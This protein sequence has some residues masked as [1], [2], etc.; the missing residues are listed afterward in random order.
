MK[1]TMLRL[2]SALVLVALAGCASF[3]EIKAKADGGDPSMQYRVGVC[4]RD[5]KDVQRNLDTAYDYFKK[6]ADGGSFA[7]AL[8]YAKE[9][10][11]RKDISEPEKFLERIQQVFIGKPQNGDDWDAR[12]EFRN[13]YPKFCIQYATLLR[14]DGALSK[15]II[16]EKQA[17]QYFDR[18]ILN[19]R[20]KEVNRHAQRLRSLRTATEANSLQRGI[21]REPGEELG[22][23]A[24]RVD[25][26]FNS[27]SWDNKA[28]FAA[29]EKFHEEFGADFSQE[30]KRK[31]GEND[32]KWV[33]RIGQCVATLTANGRAIDITR[34]IIDAEFSNS[35][36]DTALASVIRRKSEEAIDKWAERVQ[37]R[38]TP[39]DG[40]N[41]QL[42]SQAMDYFSKEFGA[43]FDRKAGEELDIWGKRVDQFFASLGGNSRAISAAREI[44]AAALTR[45][46]HRKSGEELDLWKKRVDELLSTKIQSPQLKEAIAEI[47]K[48]FAREFNVEKQNDPYPYSTQ[49]K[50]I[51]LPD[52]YFTGLSRKWA[53]TQAKLRFDAFFDQRHGILH[54][55]AFRIHGTQDAVD[56]LIAKYRKIYPEL[57]H[58]RKTERDGKTLSEEAFSAKVK[59]NNYTDTLES[60]RMEIEIMSKCMTGIEDFNIMDYNNELSD[61]QKKEL[62][63]TFTK[64][65]RSAFEKSAAVTVI[66]KK[67]KQFLETLKE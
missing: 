57:K 16:F 11:R 63:E 3:E 22:K 28:L 1:K 24:A 64:Q 2:A 48:K 41:L 19:I 61:L 53:K 49:I 46:I 29:E 21:H 4:Y 56:K 12:W 31:P 35:K 5:G 25:Q 27:Y 67:M 15:F 6:S 66:D 44:F 40:S 52:G 62:K 8:C 17:L 55:A 18:D 47:Q 36:F 65:M 43:A 37:L 51:K 30:I 50:G 38:M 32:D 9:A 20:G 13:D 7:G 60:D 54:S 14:N 42:T 26:L 39:F 33:E 23:W 10:L 34:E 58:T 45:E 59:W